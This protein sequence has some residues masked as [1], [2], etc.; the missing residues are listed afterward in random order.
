LEKE[1][2]CL[3]RIQVMEERGMFVTIRFCF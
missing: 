2:E 3:W 1:N